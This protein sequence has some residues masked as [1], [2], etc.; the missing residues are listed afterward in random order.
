MLKNFLLTALRSFKRV[1][2][3]PGAVLITE[4]KAKNYLGEADPIGKT[5]RYPTPLIYCIR[6]WLIA[7]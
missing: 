3:K 2:N 4:S 6:D 7:N 5:I 1:L